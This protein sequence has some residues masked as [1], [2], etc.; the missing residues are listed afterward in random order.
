MI[1]HNAACGTVNRK[2]NCDGKG[3]VD[4]NFGDELRKKQTQVIPKEDR[5]DRATIRA[6]LYGKSI[7]RLCREA[8]SQRKSICEGYF[9]RF[10]S[11]GGRGFELVDPEQIIRSDIHTIKDP[12]TIKGLRC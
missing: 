1:P 12:Y 6:D 8:A 2:R 7:E 9:H 3:C 4:M 5:A 11:D 10:S